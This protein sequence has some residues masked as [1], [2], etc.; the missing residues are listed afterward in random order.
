MLFSYWSQRKESDVLNLKFSAPDQHEE[1]VH[2]KIGDDGEGW[3]DDV[4]DDD[5]DDGDINYL[6]TTSI[7]C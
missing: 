1:I 4:D 5:D 7:G 2:H 6:M 3:Y